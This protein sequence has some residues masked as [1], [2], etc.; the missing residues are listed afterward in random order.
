MSVDRDMLDYYSA[1]AAEY[2]KVY[3]KPER[4]HDVATLRE[5]IPAFFTRRRVLEVACGTGYWTRLIA[6]E[7]SSITGTDLSE[8]VLQLARARQPADHA[9]TFAV[10][11]AFHLTGVPGTYDAAFVGFWWSH[12]LRGDV[13]PFLLGL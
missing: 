10:G 4:Q 5:S 9:A 8:A 12:V 6:R 2:E 7:A 1:R 11:D 3:D 13:L